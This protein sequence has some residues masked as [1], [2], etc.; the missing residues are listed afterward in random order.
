[1]ISCLG[2]WYFPRIRV[3]KCV[4]AMCTYSYVD[5]WGRGGG[6][7]SC[8]M[9]SSKLWL[10]LRMKQGLTR[11]SKSEPARANADRLRSSWILWIKQNR[12]GG[13]FHCLIK[14]ETCFSSNALSQCLLSTMMLLLLSDVGKCQLK[15]RAATLKCSFM[16]IIK[17]KGM[18]EG[19]E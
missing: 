4:C 12:R 6:G 2:C 9:H 14:A 13:H 3:C 7:G 10:V 15:T 5:V 11:R 19:H 17:S 18:L 1:M 8:P 16:G